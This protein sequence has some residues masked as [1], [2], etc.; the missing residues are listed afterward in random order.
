MKDF[1]SNR[2]GIDIFPGILA[3]LQIATFE[4]FGPPSLSLHFCSSLHTLILMKIQS[5]TERRLLFPGV[6]PHSFLLR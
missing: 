3:S 6:F 4:S 2:I 5:N 1:H